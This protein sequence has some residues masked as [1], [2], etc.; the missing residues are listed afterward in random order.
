VPACHSAKGLA[1]LRSSAPLCVHTARFIKGL[2]YYNTGSKVPRYHGQFIGEEDPNNGGKNGIRTGD[3]FHNCTCKSML[4]LLC[5]QVCTFWLPSPPA[6][7]ITGFVS[8]NHAGI[9]PEGRRIKTVRLRVRPSRV[10]GKNPFVNGT[11]M[12]VDMVRGRAHS[13]STKAVRAL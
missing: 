5:S 11:Q 3:G 4:A 12:H 13:P 9:I 1:S 10:F 2:T 6:D 7:L 8:C